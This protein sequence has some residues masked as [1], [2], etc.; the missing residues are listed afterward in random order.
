MSR[1]VQD[2]TLLEPTRGTL[3]TRS[4]GDTRTNQSRKL[5]VRAHSLLVIAALL[6]TT[7]ACGR[8]AVAG[9]L[10]KVKLFNI[11]PQSLDKALL[12]FGMQA[13]VQINFAWNPSTSQLRTAAVKGRYAGR[14]VLSQLL[15][16]TGLRYSLHGNTVEVTPLNSR[17]IPSS[18]S[19]RRMHDYPSA[20]KDGKAGD[21]DTRADPPDTPNHIHRQAT[22]S[23]AAYALNEVMV[24]AQKY[25]QPAFDVPISLNVVS[26][27]TLLQHGI[28]DLNSLQYEVPG[29]H[30]DSTGFTHGVYLRGVGNTLGNGAMVGQYI[31]DADITAEGTFNAYATGDDGLYDLNRVEVLKGPQGTL[32]GDGSLGGVIRYITNVPILDRVQMN[33]DVAAMFTQY[34]APS[35]RVETM[36]NTPIVSGVF[37]LRIAGLFEHDGG[38]VDEPAADL[39]NINDSNRVDVRAE[40]LWQPVRRLK[41]NAMEIIHRHTYGLGTG[42][43]AS[44]DLTPLFG[45]TFAPHGSD[46]SDLSNVAITYDFGTVQLLSSSTHLK[47]V[48]SIDNINSYESIGSNTFWIQIPNFNVNN[49]ESSEELRLTHDDG[50]P[51]RWNAG[52]FFKHSRNI[53][54]EDE[55]FGPAG[56]TLASALRIAVPS[57]QSTSVLWAGFMNGSYVLLDR[58]TLGAGVRYSKDR[59][60]YFYLQQFPAAT[61]TSTDPRF[62]VQYRIGRHV[63]AYA[64][65]SKGFRSGGFNASLAAPRYK[66]ESLWSYDLGSKVRFAKAGIG[67]NMD[68]FYMDYT[69]YVASTETPLFP[70]L[71][72]NVGKARIEGVDANIA[73]RPLKEWRFSLDVEALSTKFLTATQ[74]SGYAPGDRL[75]YAP[76]YSFTT[77]MRRDFQMQGKPAYVELYYYEISR[78]QYRLLGFPLSQSDVLRFANARIGIHWSDSVQFDLFLH[79]ILNDRGNASVLFAYGESTRPR[80]R[81]FG[82]EFEA[83]LP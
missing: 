49:E 37:G 76:Q 2:G 56:S 54:L 65:A 23:Q 70:F 1:H 14:A 39:K 31:N 40:A 50:G 60:T 71:L 62:Y 4:I 68:L 51:L 53:P 24:T 75:P 3:M 82:V 42:E 12:E 44:G 32:Y 77:S 36:L 80:P 16:G 19:S 28:T 26:G 33:A 17:A 69:N 18:S 34:G 55:Y 83:A 35:Q 38:W 8:V 11:P 78:T 67:A 21:E 59:E 29:L 48:E 63:N 41:V 73:W 74:L 10:D 25:R 57:A 22:E 27:D 15:N 81:T 30:M 45:T 46:N 58:I 72:A 20:T 79:N 5:R 6:I 66:P 7:A 61:F 52:G 64:S 47:E 9:D 13:Q 43:D